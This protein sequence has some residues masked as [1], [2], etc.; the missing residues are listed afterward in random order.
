MEADPTKFWPK[1]SLMFNKKMHTNFLK[2]SYYYLG[3]SKT[4]FPVL[5]QAFFHTDWRFLK[6]YNHV[7][8]GTENFYSAIY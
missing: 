4:D 2:T 6:G 8:S 1:S 3:A 5:C 7:N